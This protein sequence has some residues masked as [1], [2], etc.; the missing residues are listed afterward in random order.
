MIKLCLVL[1]APQSSLC[2]H[3]TVFLWPL[4][5]L[6][7]LLRP[8]LSTLYRTGTSHHSMPDAI[9]AILTSVVWYVPSRTCFALC[10]HSLDASLWV[11]SGTY[12]STDLKKTS[13]P[14]LSTDSPFLVCILTQIKGPPT[15]GTN[16]A[17]GLFSLQSLLSRIVRA[18]GNM[19]GK[20][21]ETTV[22]FV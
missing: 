15:L 7:P 8:G 6:C 9:P 12:P 20:R 14:R 10:S 3:H 5:N 19:N 18:Q 17:T 1:Q 2:H 11:C 21:F 4:L 13:G 22:N 16:F